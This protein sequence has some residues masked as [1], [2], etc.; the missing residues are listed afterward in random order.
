MLLLFDQDAKTLYFE[1]RRVAQLLYGNFLLCFDIGLFMITKH[2][3]TS[4]RLSA[5]R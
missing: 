2:Y 5:V 1:L 4:Q 3:R